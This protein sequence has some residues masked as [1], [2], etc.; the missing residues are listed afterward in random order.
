MAP[1]RKRLLQTHE[2]LSSEAES[3]CKKPDVLA[4]PH[5]CRDRVAETDGS[6]GLPVPPVRPEQYTSG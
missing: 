2:V 1:C 4:H 3:P 5:D 6:Q